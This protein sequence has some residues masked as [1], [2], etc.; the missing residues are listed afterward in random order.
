MH[1]QLIDDGK[2]TEDQIMILAICQYVMTSLCLIVLCWLLY[3]TFTILVKQK[4]YKVL[5]LLNF[6]VLAIPM[7]LCRTYD[8]IWFFPCIIEHE[9]TP[10]LLH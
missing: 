1:D 8:M 10:Q 3:N 5:P 9:V 4:K 6:Y 7:M 2:L